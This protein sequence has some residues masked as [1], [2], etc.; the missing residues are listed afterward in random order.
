ML[1]LYG[2]KGSG[3]AAVEAALRLAGQPFQLVDA[4]SWV[5]TP[6]L[7]KLKRMNPLVQVPTLVLDDGTVMTES[8]AIL[9]W[10]G[11]RYPQS[12]L[13]PAEPAQAIRGI[14]YIAANCYAAIGIIDYP[15]RFCAECDEGTVERIRTGTRS[16]LH[17]YWR[18]FADEFGTQMNAAHPGALDVLAAVV[19]R[20]SGARAHLAAERPAL[21]AII[22]RVEADPRITDIFRRHW[23]PK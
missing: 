16:R 7:E 8:A 2:T 12:G 18:I 6:G 9:I 17:E 23:P 15:P 14:V 20:W 19:S 22:E 3:S 21:H 13:L 4:A 10:A 1:T 5:P 11:L